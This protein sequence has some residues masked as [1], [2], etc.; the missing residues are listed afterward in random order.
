VEYQ[1]LKHE[2]FYMTLEICQIQKAM[3]PTT[4]PQKPGTFLSAWSTIYFSLRRW[5]V[6]RRKYPE[7]RSKSVTSNIQTRKICSLYKQTCKEKNKDSDTLE[8][9]VILNVVFIVYYDL[10]LD[11]SIAVGFISW[12]NCSQTHLKNRQYCISRLYP[13]VTW[14]DVDYGP[15]MEMNFTISDML[16]P[17]I[18]NKRCEIY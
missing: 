15:T 7:S 17:R 8:V 16:G 12:K 14:F 10:K 11:E 13:K 6:K 5:Q 2:N 4:S 1:S 18:A 9:L 3:K